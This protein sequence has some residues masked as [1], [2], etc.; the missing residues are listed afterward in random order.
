VSQEDCPSQSSALG[1]CSWLTSLPGLSHS[2]MVRLFQKN[3]APL[4]ISMALG[5]P[6]TI[7]RG[8]APGTLLQWDM[9]SSGIERMQL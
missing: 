1:Q 2:V 5:A 9:R 8:T 7:Y 3:K 4:T 6:S